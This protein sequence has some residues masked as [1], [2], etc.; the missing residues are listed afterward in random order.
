MTNLRNKIFEKSAF[1]RYW[2]LYKTIGLY[3][4][5]GERDDPS[6]YRP[7]SLLSPLSKVVEKAILIQFY[8][9]MDEN[10]LFNER[11]YTHKAGHS[12]LNALLDLSES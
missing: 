12:T 5:K 1:P 10:G 7:I 11:S 4:G 2:K 9:H 8:Q 3:K 6:S